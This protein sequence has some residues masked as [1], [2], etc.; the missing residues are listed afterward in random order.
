MLQDRP[1]RGDQQ[2]VSQRP[3]HR[4]CSLHPSLP[5]YY[6]PAAE[7]PRHQQNN[8]VCPETVE[9]IMLKYFSITV[10]EPQFICLH[11]DCLVIC[12]KLKYWLKL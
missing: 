4:V 3:R 12:F 6:R 9:K 2:D 7:R 5:R 10:C 1:A 11:L 8:S